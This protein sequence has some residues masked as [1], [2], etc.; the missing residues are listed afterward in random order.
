MPFSSPDNPMLMYLAP[1]PD[2]WGR[3]RD[4]NIVYYLNANIG[5]SVALK[6]SDFEHFED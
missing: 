5:D 6:L 3:L 2:F 1:E 4:N